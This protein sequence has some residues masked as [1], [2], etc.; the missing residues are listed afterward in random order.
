MC[1]LT[2]VISSITDVATWAVSFIV[3]IFSLY[4]AF[5]KMKIYELLEGKK[6]ELLFRCEK[7]RKFYEEVQQKIYKEI[8]KNGVSSKEVQFF[9]IFM[10]GFA[11]LEI[12]KKGLIQGLSTLFVP[13]FIVYWDV[14]LF[15]FSLLFSE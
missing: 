1:F 8:D 13:F 14:L 9:L 15:Q 7:F 2:D 3:Q 11:T 4:F 6:H 12:I 10:I 5:K